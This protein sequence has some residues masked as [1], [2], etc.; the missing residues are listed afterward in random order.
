MLEV[1]P[2]RQEFMELLQQMRAFREDTS[3]R[4]QELREDMARRF[5]AIIAELRAHRILLDDLQ[6][7]SREM[8]IALSSLGSRVGYGLE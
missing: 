1:F 6:R 8:A 5:E 4:F 3:Q 7:Q 2:S